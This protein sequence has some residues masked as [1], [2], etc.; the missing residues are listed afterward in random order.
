MRLSLWETGVEVASVAG[1]VLPSPLVN[2][3]TV[4]WYERA[5][6]ESK[7]V[8]FLRLLYVNLYWNLGYPERVSTP[9]KA[10]SKP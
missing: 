8:V 7:S 6:P 1:R 9:L 4:L 2:L 5:I 3:A 10:K